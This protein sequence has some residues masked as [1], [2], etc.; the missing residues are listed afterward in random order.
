MRRRTE[1]PRLLAIQCDDSYTDAGLLVSLSNGFSTDGFWKET[2]Y[3]YD[4]SDWKEVT[5][6]DSSWSSPK[7]IG[8]NNGMPND[9][10]K[11]IGF[12]EDA[13]WIW[14]SS[15][16]NYYHV[17]VAFRGVLGKNNCI[18]GTATVHQSCDQ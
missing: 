18:Q 14:S 12:G 4:Y 10:R 17:Y 11:Q 15:M 16:Y 13:R 8:Q 9:W 7:L 5:Y 1:H 2:I 3:W 6:D